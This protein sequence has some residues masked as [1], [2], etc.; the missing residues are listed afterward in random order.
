MRGEHFARWLVN[1]STFSESLSAQG[2]R[3]IEFLRIG[4]GG[5]VPGFFL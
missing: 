4:G 2:P 5:D 3:G 1:S